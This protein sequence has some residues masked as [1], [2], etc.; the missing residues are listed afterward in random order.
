MLNILLGAGFA[1][2]WGSIFSFADQYLVFDNLAGSLLV[3]TSGGASMISLFIIGKM[4]DSNPNV[5][6]YF[7]LINAT[8]SITFFVISNLI[9]M[10][11]SRKTNFSIKNQKK[12]VSIS[13]FG[14][15]VT[16]KT[17]L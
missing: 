12:R 14:G 15:A 1:T 10:L 9:I 17:K 4:I 2:M 8:I 11:W 13:S 5:L 3:T 6:I 16:F 7:H